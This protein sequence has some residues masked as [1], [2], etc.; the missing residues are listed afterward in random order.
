MR[1]EF[2]LRR[3]R[4]EISSKREK[5]GEEGEKAYLLILRVYSEERWEGTEK[6]SEEKNYPKNSFDCYN[7]RIVSL[8]CWV[9]GS[10]SYLRIIQSDANSPPLPLK[11]PDL[12]S[13]RGRQAR[14]KA[15]EEM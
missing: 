5:G 7:R 14:G 2:V 9:G 11:Q 8:D 13:V 6:N 15:D 3:V 10:R 1:R 4:S 12:A